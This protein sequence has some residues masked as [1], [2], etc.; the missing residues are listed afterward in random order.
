MQNGGDRAIGL[1]KHRQFRLILG[2]PALKKPGLI[3]V[4]DYLQGELE[5]PIKHE[6]LDGPVY[7]M[8]GA[9]NRHNDIAMNAGG[10]LFTQLRGK[11]SRPQNSD[12]KIRVLFAGSVNFYYPDLSVSCERNDENDSFQD[13]PVVIM[14]VLSKSTIAV[15]NLQFCN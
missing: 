14:A 2:V 8:P 5:S 13:K 4:E 3:S 12:T 6:Y 9:K 1:K 7:A 15:H 10:S 11:A